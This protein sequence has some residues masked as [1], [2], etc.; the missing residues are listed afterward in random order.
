[1]AK[2][3]AAAKRQSF[4]TLNTINSGGR[5]GALRQLFLNPKT[6]LNFQKFKDTMSETP[7]TVTQDRIRTHVRERYGEIAESRG[8]SCC[9]FSDESSCCSGESRA[10]KKG[11]K[12]GYSAEEVEAS[13]ESAELGLGCGN[14]TAISAIEPGETILDL[15]SGGGFDCF[16]ASRKVG[17]KG[18]VI[19]VDMTPT[20]ISIARKNAEK[21]WPKNVE[22]RLG[23]IEAL[24]VADAT[25]DAIMSNCV[26]NL[27]PNKQAVF[28]ESY[29]VLKSGGR[30][31]ISDIV[32]TQE[33][34]EY[35]AEDFATFTSCISGAA[36]VSDL[37]TMLTN[38]GFSEVTINVKEETRKM[39]SSWSESGKAGNYVASADIIAKK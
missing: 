13:L 12:L 5:M 31:Q 1:M 11:A 30:L 21:H 20:M 8:S 9:G 16:I 25:V 23:E 36:L 7:D 6:Q 22:F 4:L 35:I 38:A 24:P 19:G 26:I 17:E 37:E 14:P 18:H 27:S 29:R 2:E 10:H 39:V 33:F 34:P 15:G 32:A 28:N 3:E